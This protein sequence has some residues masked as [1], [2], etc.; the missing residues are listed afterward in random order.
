MLNR[1]CIQLAVWLAAAGTPSLA[2]CRF[3][4]DGTGRILTYAFD[5][6][7][8][9]TGTVLH[10]TLEFQGIPGGQEEVE[11][12][13]QWADET[14]HGLINLRALSAD[15]VVA[16]T[17]SPGSKT[18]RHPDQEVVL[19]YDVVKDWTGRFSHP[20]Q[21]HGAILPEYIEINGANALIHPKLSAQAQVSVNFDW[22]KLPAGWVLAT[23]FGTSS[24]S[25][26]RCQSWS[27]AWSAVEEALFAAGDFRIHRFRIG[28]RPAVLAIR[29]EWTFSDDEAIADIQKA[30]GVVRDFWHDDNF[31]YFL[32]TL[33]AFENES[34]QSDGS[35]FTNAFWLYLSRRDSISDQLPLLIHETFHVW[36]PL[37]MGSPEYGHDIEW[38]RE[39]FVRYYTNVLAFRAHLIQLPAYLETVNRDLRSF[40]SST[41]GA[42]RGPVIALW[43]DQQIRKDSGGKRS[44]DN[45]MYD[46]VSEPAN[47]LTQARIL[48]TA[49]R[50]V[51]PVSWIELAHAVEPGSRIPAVEDAPG[52][53]VRGSV[54]EIAT[55]NLGFDLAASTAAGS[56]TGVEPG[57]PA[58]Q[59]GL[60]NGQRL[61][62]K[63]LSVYN[64][65]PEKIAIVTVQTGDGPRAIEY[66]P[67]G[68]PVK[69]MQYHLDQQAYAADPVSCQTLEPGTGRY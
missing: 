10:V 49:G 48:E 54:E 4:A 63:R 39:G 30:V 65:H 2:Q 67:R 27:G 3:P 58:F 26:D 6:T 34:G 11:V 22:N 53:C 23:S 21:F 51:S 17:T 33:K 15:T 52:P 62:G 57:G 69:V 61:S 42:V 12:P 41:S 8:T 55:F 38:F 1:T 29:G 16:D 28:V 66:Y 19:A 5:P 18:V 40:P 36:D 14:L 35:A 59:A 68:A 9:S 56:V 43:L 7:V 37:R 60:R 31:P 25:N 45:V 47:P 24:D 64:N 44:L 50:Y 32:V 46:M 13:S 20:A